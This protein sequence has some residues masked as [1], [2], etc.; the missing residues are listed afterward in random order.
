MMV[1]VG[2]DVVEFFAAG[3]KD[4]VQDTNKDRAYFSTSNRGNVDY[5]EGEKVPVNVICLFLL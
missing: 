5:A 3:E 1:I 4:G 2:D